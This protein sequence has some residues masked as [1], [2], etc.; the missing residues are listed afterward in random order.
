MPFGAS[1]TFLTFFG[2][3]INNFPS[4]YNLFCEL[5]PSCP[6]YEAKG[7]IRSIPFAI[8][9]RAVA[10]ALKPLK[11]APLLCILS[12]KAAPLFI[13]FPAGLKA[14]PERAWSKKSVPS[15]GGAVQLPVEI[16]DP[17]I[18]PNFFKA[19]QKHR[20]AGARMVFGARGKENGEQSSCLSPKNPAGPA[21]RGLRGDG[22]AACRRNPPDISLFCVSKKCKNIA[23][24]A[25]PAALR[26]FP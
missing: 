18:G 11:G 7:R 16:N 12:K 3:F 1:I 23:S 13:H 17:A 20:L 19:A 5:I 26:G 8:T 21:V 15:T 10:F 9:G 14:R 6:Q 22:K 25:T 2:C 4:K 24:R